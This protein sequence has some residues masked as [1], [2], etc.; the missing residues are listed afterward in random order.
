MK[1]IVGKAQ[2]RCL[3]T[4]AALVVVA[5]CT[6]SPVVRVPEPEPAVPPRI[7]AEAERQAIA[8]HRKLAQEA[9]R[10]GNYADAI[11]QWQILTLLVPGDATFRDALI[12]A[13]TSVNNGVRE[14]M[15]TANAALAANDAERATQALLRTLALD[16]ENTDAARMLRDIDRRRMAR[17][18]ADRAARVRIQDA[19]AI[20]NA[21]QKEAN[22]GEIG[23]PFDIDQAI[24]MF[25]AGD[26]AGGLRE[27]RAYVDAHPGN[28]IARQRAAQV[29][30]DRA[31]ELEDK[32]ANAE[33]QNLYDQAS[34]LYGAKAPWSARAESL[35][36]AAGSGVAKGKPGPNPK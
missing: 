7:N 18:Q 2:W 27:L 26:T 21:V 11:A 12:A 20:K 13:R 22:A 30:A 25:R 34:G 9:T 4:M 16:P 14:L 3:L 15:A 28:R 35:R 17:L 29:V 8:R 6:P 31:R 32:G 5:G 1:Q 10:T 36:K 23:Q 19:M 33:A 24:E